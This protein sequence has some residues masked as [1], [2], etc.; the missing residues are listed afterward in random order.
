MPDLTTPLRVW[1]AE[2]SYFTG[3]LEAY[4]RYKEIPYER[5][6]AKGR[7]FGGTLPARTGAMQIPAVELPDSPR[8][9]RVGYH[10]SLRGRS[11]W[12][13]AGPLRSLVER[14]VSRRAL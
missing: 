14:R 7:D 1:G 2:R 13:V 6:S 9:T 12:V 5:I 4:L 11:A 3:K 8:G 10:E